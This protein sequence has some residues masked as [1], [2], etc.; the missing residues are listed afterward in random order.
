MASGIFMQF[1]F[2][3]NLRQTKFALQYI[4]LLVFLQLTIV[5]FSWMLC[6]V[7]NLRPLAV[8]SRFKIAICYRAV[9]MF[10]LLLYEIIYSLI[11]TYFLLNLKQNLKSTSIMLFLVLTLFFL[12]LL[13]VK[14]LLCNQKLAFAERLPFLPFLAFLSVCG[15]NV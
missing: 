8:P 13:Y 15:T 7:I 3:G 2:K 9:F 11:K 1:L 14:G 4:I 5:A 10:A 12:L 6:N